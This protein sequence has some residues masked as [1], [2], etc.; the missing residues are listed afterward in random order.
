MSS[1]IAQNRINSLSHR[2]RAQNDSQF[3][4]R[5]LK[6]GQNCLKIKEIMKSMSGKDEF[7][8][9]VLTNNRNRQLETT[10]LET[11][12]LGTAKLETT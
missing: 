7:A 5:S 2:L 4:A 8:A 6:V 11:A 9:A 3:L 12:K 10:Q 1:K